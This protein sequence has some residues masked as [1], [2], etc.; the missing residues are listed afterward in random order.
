VI[1]NDR[2]MI[3]FGARK[4]DKKMLTLLELHRRST[5]TLLVGLKHIFVVLTERCG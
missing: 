5:A 4:L 2:P 3:S 1:F